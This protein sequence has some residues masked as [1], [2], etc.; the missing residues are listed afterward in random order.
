MKNDKV[1][2]LDLREPPIYC[3]YASGPCDQEF[4]KEYASTG[5]FLYPSKPINVAIAIEGAVDL[6]K[7]N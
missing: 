5:V 3:Q 7:Q 2:Q 1:I 4:S 6:L